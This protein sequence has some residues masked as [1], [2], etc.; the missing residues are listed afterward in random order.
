MS[1]LQ[2]RRKTGEAR[3]QKVTDNG[4]ILT[5]CLNPV[6]QKT[7]VLTGLEEGEVNRSGDYH[8]HVAGKGI[9]VSRVLAQLGERVTHITIKDGMF[10]PIFDTLALREPYHIIAVPSG[11]ELR[12]CYTL[13]NKKK[14]TATEI[15]E[16]GARVNAGTERRIL[17][18]FRRELKRCRA[19]V[20]S[21][22]KAP[23]FSRNLFPIMV[24]ESKAAG[25]KVL[26]D[27]RGDDLLS[28]LTHRPDAVKPNYREFIDT[29]FPGKRSAV[30]SDDVKK[31]MLDIAEQYDTVV[32]VTRGAQAILYTDRGSVRVFVP[33]RIVPVNPIGSGDS[34]A[35]GFFAAFLGGESLRLAV[36]MGERCARLNALRLMPGTIR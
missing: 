6:L 32:I 27:Y 13:I 19:V 30:T 24:K 1:A 28:S 17:A 29:F 10:E 9:H 34:F 5:V 31:K 26:L 4:V 35:A 20:I 23:G 36:G 2:G 12:F 33:T 15:V 8:L 22:S 7:I 3:Q 18:V 21:G 16:E 14:H 25:K 11:A